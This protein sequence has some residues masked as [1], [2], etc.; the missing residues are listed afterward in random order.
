MLAAAPGHVSLTS[1]VVP[2]AEPDRD[3]ETGDMAST[4]PTPNAAALF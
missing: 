4:L 1:T 3:K 2:Y